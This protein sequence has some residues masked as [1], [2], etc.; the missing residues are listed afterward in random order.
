MT[1]RLRSVVHD[2]VAAHLPIHRERDRLS[3]INAKLGG[4]HER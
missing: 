1:G 2:Q 4:Q 3:N